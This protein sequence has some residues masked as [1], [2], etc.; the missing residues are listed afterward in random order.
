MPRNSA[1][2]RKPV[3]TMS[4]DPVQDIAAAD[5]AQNMFSDGNNRT[6]QQSRKSVKGY[7][8]AAHTRDVDTTS[9]YGDGAIAEDLLESTVDT[10]HSRDGTDAAGRDD[11]DGGSLGGTT[12]ELDS[13]EVS[14]VPVDKN[15]RMKS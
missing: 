3:T 9:A 7:D 14:G 10:F 12:E 4:I 8:E 13:L 15:P 6:A 2:K 5:Y 1:T 11:E